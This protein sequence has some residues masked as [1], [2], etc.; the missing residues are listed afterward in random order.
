MDNNKVLSNK[1]IFQRKIF[2]LC[3]F[4]ILLISLPVFAD[5]WDASKP[6]HATLYA[7]TLTSKTDASPVSIADSQGLFVTGDI[8]ALGK[9]GIGTDIDAGAAT[10]IAAV[11]TTARFHGFAAEMHR[12]RATV[13]RDQLD[14]CFIYEFHVVR[15]P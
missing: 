4:F 2:L 3:I 10:T 13:A 1:K 6:S 9:V 7:D 11:G 8:I 12:A 15:S 14:L 5:G